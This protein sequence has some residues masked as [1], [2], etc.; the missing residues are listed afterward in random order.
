LDE[1]CFWSMTI[2][3]W[4]WHEKIHYQCLKRWI[5]CLKS[6][7]HMLSSF[8]L[9]VTNQNDNLYPLTKYGV[10]PS[11]GLH[12]FVCFCKYYLG[13]RFLYITLNLK[14]YIYPK[15]FYLIYISIILCYFVWKI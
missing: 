15:W 3:P 9:Q 7:G 4:F 13:F 2:L 5:L 11:F 14:P 6:S 1:E 12:A 10:L 8:V